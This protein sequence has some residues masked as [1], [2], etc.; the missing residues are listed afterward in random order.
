MGDIAAIT[1][2][3]NRCRIGRGATDSELFHGLHQ[4]R[5][6]VAARGLSLVSLCLRLFKQRDFPFAH[7][8][9]GLLSIGRFR[10]VA[11]LVLAFLVG[12]PEAGGSNNSSRGAGQH[13]VRLTFDLDIGT[14]ADGCGKA[15]GIG[16]L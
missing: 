1:N 12:Q 4:G 16:H 5:F 2:G 9:E 7:L 13:C 10:V 14:Y 3:L 15:K 8:R 6:G 11:S